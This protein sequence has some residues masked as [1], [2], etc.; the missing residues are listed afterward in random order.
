MEYMLHHIQ[1][2]IWPLRLAD[3]EEINSEK[4]S[5]MKSVIRGRK[6]GKMGK[7]KRS[8]FQLIVNLHFTPF[9][10]FLLTPGVSSFN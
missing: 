4:I 2:N 1:N 6:E 7:R 10:F 8:G 5:K 9:P 3:G